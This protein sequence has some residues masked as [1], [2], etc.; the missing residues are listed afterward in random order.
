MSAELASRVRQRI[1]VHGVEATPAAIVT[2]V[3]AES[4]AAVLG[5][6]TVLPPP[7]L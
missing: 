1:A 6:A 3:R 7:K 2:A 5:D 4:G